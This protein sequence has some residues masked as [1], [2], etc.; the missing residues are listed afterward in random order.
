MASMRTKYLDAVALICALAYALT[1]GVGT[2]RLGTSVS[3]RRTAAE[4][5]FAELVDRSSSAAVLGFMEAPFRETVRDA[6]RVSEAL[7]AA[8]VTGPGG[9]EYAVERSPGYLVRREGSV[10]FAAVFGASH[11]PFF[12]PLRAGSV[13]NATLSAV[14]LLVDRSLLFAIL[15]DTLVAVAAIT[16]F[17]SLLLVVDIL[18]SSPTSSLGE[19]PAPAA[20]TFETATRETEEFDID[21]PDLAED[22]KA[23][24]IGIEPSPAIPGGET[25][26][27]EP[28]AA[29]LSPDDLT[30]EIGVT[31]G[32]PE[33]TPPESTPPESTAQA[34][35]PPQSAPVGL[36]SPRGGIGWEA[37]TADRLASE[38][39]RCASFEQDLV[40]LIMEPFG[41]PGWEDSFAEFAESTVSF[42]TFRDLVFERGNSGASVILPNVDLD[43]GLRMAEEFRCKLSKGPTPAIADADLRIGLTARSGRL[44]DAERLMLEAARALAKAVEEEGSPVV[45]FKPDP[46]RYRSFIAARS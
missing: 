13:R 36:Y 20:E 21:I 31:L 43:H 34:S 23:D 37:Y 8:I 19:A 40:L 2:F 5:E 27:E 38:L 18:R 35:A 41:E 3:E 22:I 42:F 39:H 1:L 32:E 10:A 33:S 17:A 46:D 16:A 15:R 11:D 4:R 25:A 30:A 14:A 6:V 9:P 12:A 7:A 44:V 26:M 24:I 29:D 28:A 45:A